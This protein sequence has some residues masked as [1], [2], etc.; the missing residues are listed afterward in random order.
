MYKS[1]HPKR[2]AIIPA[3][4]GSKRLP[5]KNLL[6]V[7]GKPLIQHTIEAVIN[8][9]SFSKVLFSSDSDEMLQFAS[10][11][12]E[13][14]AEKREEVLA[15]DEVKVI[16]LV[17]TLADMDCY[18]DFDQIGLFLPTCP[19]R[20]QDHINH[21]LKLLDK[22]HYSVV[23]ICEMSDPLQL[24]VTMDAETNVIDPCGVLDPSPLVSGQTRSQEFKKYFRVNGGFYIAW[25][26][27]FRLRNNFFQGEVKGFVMDKLHSIDIDHQ[28]DLDMANLLFEKN[29]LNL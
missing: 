2:L 14:S 11:F 3:R 12:K 6:E 5:G 21:G 26:D 19:F 27:K 13:V 9:K 24:S 25:L 1:S 10:K 15:G 18:D 29:Y 22:D 28:F 8:S 16:D 23:S 20:N 17:K 4:G 7:G